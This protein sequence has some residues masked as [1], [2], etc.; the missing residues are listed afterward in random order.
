MDKNE[1]RIMNIPISLSVSDIYQRYSLDAYRRQLHAATHKTTTEIDEKNTKGDERKD[2]KEKEKERE[3]EKEQQKE[4]EKKEQA[5]AANNKEIYLY[6][7]SNKCTTPQD[8]LRRIKQKAS[9]N[10]CKNRELLYRCLKIFYARKDQK[11]DENVGTVTLA[12]FDQ[13]ID[14]IVKHAKQELE[15]AAA[16]VASFSTD[17][18]VDSQV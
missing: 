4:K 8:I 7:A 14:E 2:D 13:W 17:S 11:D 15:K 10:E 3:R 16:A 6:V 5:D 12:E 18:F 9:L 1:I